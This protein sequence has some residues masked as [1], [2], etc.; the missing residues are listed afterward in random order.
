[1]YYLLRVE[2]AC[3]GIFKEPLKAVTASHLFSPLE[4]ALSADCVLSSLLLMAEE[5]TSLGDKN[6][7]Q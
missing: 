4:V 6:A 5:E 1:M 7:Q 3:W 2:Y